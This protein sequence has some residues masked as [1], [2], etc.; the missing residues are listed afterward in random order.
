M[1]LEWQERGAPFNIFYIQMLG[2]LKQLHQCTEAFL[3]VL[4]TGIGGKCFNQLLERYRPGPA[5]NSIFAMG[6]SNA[7][8]NPYC[9]RIFTE[10]LFAPICRHRSVNCLLQIK[11]GGQCSG[12]AGGD[13]EALL[14][15]LIF[16]ESFTKHLGGI[17]GNNFPGVSAAL[18]KRRRRNL[19]IICSIL[20]GF[21]GSLFDR[22][23]GS[24]KI[25]CNNL[26]CVLGI[27]ARDH[28]G[29]C[30]YALD[31]VIAEGFKPP[32]QHGNIGSLP[33]AVGVQFIKNQVTE[34]R[35]E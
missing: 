21:L 30:S 11:R 2:P 24:L 25:I 33:T 16:R 18:C 23:R 13:L 9:K 28:R 3:H 26:P 22:H 6:K 12:V 35:A 20:S 5:D 34:V 7:V 4:F 29:G 31:P 17:T 1:Y 15:D 32:D 19:E 14:N 8:F 10:G 27:F